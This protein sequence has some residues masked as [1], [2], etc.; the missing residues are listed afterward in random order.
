[1]IVFMVVS[2][3][4][5]KVVLFCWLLKMAPKIIKTSFEE[6]EYLFYLPWVVSEKPMQMNRW[7]MCSWK[8]SHVM[9][10]SLMW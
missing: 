2:S 5:S 9:N 1:V 3:Q 6:N 8:T 4:I 7:Y 10:N